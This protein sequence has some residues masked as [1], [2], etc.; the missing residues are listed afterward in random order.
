MECKDL[1][2]EAQYTQADALE[3]QGGLQSAYDLFNSLTGYRDAA[4]RAEDLAQRLGI[5][6][7]TNN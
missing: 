5:D 4:Q 2:R 7:S 3:T 1:Y 6:T